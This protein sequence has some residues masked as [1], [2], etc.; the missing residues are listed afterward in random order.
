MRG[1]SDLAE[2]V[3]TIIAKSFTQ[4]KAY[5]ESATSDK[6]ILGILKGN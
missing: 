5:I 1:N 2:K 4:R 6:Y 3:S